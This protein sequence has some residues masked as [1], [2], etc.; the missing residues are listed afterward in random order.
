MDWSI[1]SRF[2]FQLVSSCITSM[3]S[4]EVPHAVCPKGECIVAVELLAHRRKEPSVGVN[5]SLVLQE[6][7]SHFSICAPESKTRF[8]V[9]TGSTRQQLSPYLRQHFPYAYARRTQY[10]Q[11]KIFCRYQKLLQQI[12]KLVGPPHSQTTGVEPFQI[13][14][15]INRK[16]LQL[17]SFSQDYLW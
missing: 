5:S 8:L 17:P 6:C 12:P 9:S 13:Q 7:I 16:V 10:F 14:S 4:G 11:N 3:R 15:K 2:S 1:I